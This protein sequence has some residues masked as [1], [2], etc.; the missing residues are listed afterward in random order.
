MTL[1]AQAYLLCGVSR[2]MSQQTSILYGME[3]KTRY[4]VLFAILNAPSTLLEDSIHLRDRLQTALSVSPARNDHINLKR[5]IAKYVT[6][7]KSIYIIF[8]PVITLINSRKAITLSNQDDLIEYENTTNQVPFD[9]LVRAFF[10][11]L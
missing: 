10:F 11:F 8:T 7:F 9:N 4:L 3:K 2:I 6:Y 5:P 1:K